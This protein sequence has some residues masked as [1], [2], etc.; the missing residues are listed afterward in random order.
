MLVG[1]GPQPP[2][3]ER[4][5][6]L[7]GLIALIVVAVGAGIVTA[8][9]VFGE[10]RD[11][12]EGR[13]E[14]AD[15]AVTL[16]EVRRYDDLETLHTLGDVDYAQVPPVGGQ[17]YPTWLDCGVYDAPVADEL[18]VH[19]L[20]HGT[21][22]LTHDPDLSADELEVLADALPANGILSPYPGMDA[23]VV[24]TVWGRQLA[25]DGADDPRLALFV[26]EYGA[27]E[28]APE[29]F[30]SCAGGVRGPGGLPADPGSGS[31][32]QV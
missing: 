10:D 15:A 32:R 9:S 16:D 19:A 5:A 3:R 31:G 27:G 25:L 26:A 12:R 22:W 24:V 23:P 2:R 11:D 8:V 21:V 29:P 6:W 14:R 18:A 28:T 4:S 17:H 1:S 30:A 20:E 7:S 13:L